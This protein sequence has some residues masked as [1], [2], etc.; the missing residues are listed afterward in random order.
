MKPLRFNSY[1]LANKVQY[2]VSCYR[3]GYGGHEKNDEVSG[4]GNNVDMGDRW[5]DTRLGR[6]FKPDVKGHLYPDLSPYS[7]AANNPIFFIDPDGK[8]IK[9]TKTFLASTYGGLYSGLMKNNS[10]YTSILAKYK[11][12]KTF[13]FTLYYGDKGVSKGA[14]AT[15]SSSKQITTTTQGEKVLSKNITGV[16]SNSYYGETAQSKTSEI[17]E[18]GKTMIV[19]MNKTDIANVKTLFHEAIHANI[20]TTFTNDDDAHN[21]YSKYQSTL[22][23]GLKEYNTDNKLGYSDDQLTQLSWAGIHESKGFK[24]YIT[25]L[26]KANGTTYDEEYSKWNKAVQDLQWKET[27]REEKKETPTATPDSTKH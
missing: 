18:D 16:E 2:D 27:K 14:N 22:L 12:S 13:N 23:K 10:S 7:Y 25:G 1:Y 8:E 24:S 15:T 11:G 21:S 9:P 6:T 20:A 3:F 17:V 26:S 19:T 4:S 5:L